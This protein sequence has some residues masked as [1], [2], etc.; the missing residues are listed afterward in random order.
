MGKPRNMHGK[1]A[2]YGDENPHIMRN[3]KT[4]H[5]K[6]GETTKQEMRTFTVH[7]MVATSPIRIEYGTS[8]VLQ[9]QAWRR[10]EIVQLSDN[11][12]RLP[13]PCNML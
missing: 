10:L 6:W 9:L 11:S 7:H 3:G 12:M 4:T 2:L 5:D 1:P 13:N 8:I